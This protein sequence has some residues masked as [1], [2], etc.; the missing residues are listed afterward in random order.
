LV[1]VIGGLSLL[2]SQKK[3]LGLTPENFIPKAFAWWMAICGKV[4]VKERIRYALDKVSWSVPL[5]PSVT[6]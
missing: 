6:S 3:K 1:E 2:A 4:G 5:L